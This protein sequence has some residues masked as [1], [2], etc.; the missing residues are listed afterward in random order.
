[1]SLL[2]S[3]GRGF[4]Y[5]IGFPFFLIVLL[6]TAVAGLFMLIFMFFKSI[7]L[8]FTGR[9]LD[10]D[11]PEDKKAKRIKAGLPPTET[12]AAPVQEQPIVQEYHEQPAPTPAPAPAPIIIN[13]NQ[14]SAPAPAPVP[15]PI[16]EPEPELEPEQEPLI[17]SL[18]EPEFL[19]E[20]VSEEV[21]T[22]IKP[23]IEEE[24]IVEKPKMGQYIPKNSTPRF[25]EEE[26]DLK[27]DDSGVDILY[28]DDD[29]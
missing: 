3:I 20:P 12:P 5:I 26:E 10:D 2:K 14:G 25:I 11:L 28:G 27:D 6:G 23:I 9:S 7:F 22:E 17:E 19:D 24:P 21:E 29:D 13:V 18:S 15:E 16:I 1:M 4:L 8:F